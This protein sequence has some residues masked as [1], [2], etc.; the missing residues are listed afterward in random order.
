MP[1]SRPIRVDIDATVVQVFDHYNLALSRNIGWV[2]AA[3]QAELRSKR[4]A[5]AGLGGVGGARFLTLER[6]GIG[7]FGLAEFGEF[8][9]VNLNRQAGAMISTLG[10]PRLDALIAMALDI[11]LELDIRPLP[12][13]VTAA[14]VDEFLRGADLYVDGLDFFAFRRGRRR[15]DD[16]HPLR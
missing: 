16:G 9:L 4:V 6:L 2:T 12:D 1:T 13:G 5:I 7:A 10:P 11:N 8:D 14:N 15:A 3:S